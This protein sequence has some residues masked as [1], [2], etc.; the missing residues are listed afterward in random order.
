MAV[1]PNKDKPVSDNLRPA[2]KGKYGNEK[3]PDEQFGHK[4]NTRFG[5]PTGKDE[6]QK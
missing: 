6:E 5:N 3:N 2:G 4:L 1:K